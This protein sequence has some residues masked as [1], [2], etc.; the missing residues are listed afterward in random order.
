MNKRFVTPILVA[1]VLL[2]AACHHNVENVNFDFTSEIE[3]PA[4]DQNTTKVYLQD[5]FY[6]H[7]EFGEL[8]SMGS[9]LTTEGD[10]GNNGWLKIPDA[11]TDFDI[12]NAAFVTSLPEGSTAFLGLYPYNKDNIIK[13]D[14]GS[15]NT[16]SQVFINLPTEQ[17]LRTDHTFAQNS[18]P[19]VAWYGGDDDPQ[20][21]FNLKFYA[22]G[23]IARFQLF[24]NSD[25]HT[26]KKIVFTSSKNIAGLF[27]VKDYN[28][29]N[30]KPVG[31]NANTI[32]IDCGDGVLL[33]HD[34]LRSFYLVL[35]ASNGEN[36]AVDYDLTMTVYTTDEYQ[37]AKSLPVPIRRRGIT[38]INA[39]GISKWVKSGDGEATPGLVGN[40]DA[41]RPF[42]IYTYKDLKYLQDCFNN[43]VGGKVYINNQEVTKDTYFRL[44]RTDIVL[45]NSTQPW[46]G[47]RDFIGHLSDYANVPVGNVKGITNNSSY[48]L[49][50][51]IAEGGTVSGIVVKRNASSSGSTFSP[52]CATNNGVIEN[53]EI[54]HAGNGSITHDNGNL[55]GI[56]YTNN[57]TIS[58]SG[59]KARMAVG[60][61]RNVAGICYTNNGTIERCYTATQMAVTQ[62]QNVAGVCYNN[63]G[64]VRDCYFATTYTTTSTTS[65]GG[66]VYNNTNTGTIEHCSLGETASIFTNGHVGSIAHTNQG[67][68]DHCSSSALLK[69]N[70][71]GGL[72]AEQSGASAIIR[73]SYV[74]NDIVALQ[75]INDASATA[76]G[77][78]VGSMAGG[79]IENC[80]TYIPHTQRLGTMGT[81]GGFVGNMTGGTIRNCYCYELTTPHR[82]FYGS[83]S[84]TCT[85]ENCFLIDDTQDGITSKSSTTD[86]N[87]TSEGLLY[88]LN[89]QA[90]SHDDWDLWMEAASD[91]YRPILTT[92]TLPTAK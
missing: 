70:L 86:F 7:F 18:Y 63:A 3:Q 11:G 31:G 75:L 84:G 67:T 29:A 6:I 21:K 47:I 56:C 27:N 1:L 22:L 41:I 23:G 68:I 44:M 89:E 52:F 60:A 39:F 26:V 45:N 38:Y 66:I 76:I 72:V 71:V 40:G 17:P 37:Y 12:Y 49:F 85:F 28:T 59:C 19:M 69:G 65:W 50:T 53:C 46:E 5:E 88:L 87:A 35:P 36:Q 55:A 14:G 54:L 78:I 33:D 20:S 10:E 2:L 74:D 73:N 90:A 48:P 58:G 34:S 79:T 61:S 62:A 83:K 80:Y 81:D 16:F 82:S 32:T 8:I 4:T 43:P 25:P 9:N 91:D 24:N 92:Y 77:G 15:S 64:T 51:S 57:G 42:K 13:G 30:P